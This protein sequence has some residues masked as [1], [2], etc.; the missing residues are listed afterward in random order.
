MQHCTSLALCEGQWLMCM[1]CVV[2]DVYGVLCLKL[3]CVL[4]AFSEGQQ[5][6]CVLS[7]VL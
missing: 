1:V 2:V 7:V 6:R 4:R 3:W 5:W